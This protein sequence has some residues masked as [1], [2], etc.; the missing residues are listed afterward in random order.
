MTEIY[1]FGI[2]D[3][4]VT[5]FQMGPHKCMESKCGCVVTRI[6]GMYD[7]DIFCKELFNTKQVTL[8]PQF[9]CRVT[10]IHKGQLG[11]SKD[12]R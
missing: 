10:D 7:I 6:R 11:R 12:E 5:P 1:L 8:R 3:G 2:V 4:H 9:Q